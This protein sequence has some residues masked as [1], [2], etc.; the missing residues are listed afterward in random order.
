MVAVIFL[1]LSEYKS[2]Y[3][4]RDYFGIISDV[5]STPTISNLLKLE[6]YSVGVAE[7]EKANGCESVMALR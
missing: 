7:S 3:E 2:T 6:A 1:L 5:G 4:C